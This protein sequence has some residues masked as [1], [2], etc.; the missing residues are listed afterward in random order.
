MTSRGSSLRADAAPF[1]PQNTNYSNQQQ[2]FQSPEPP[3][4]T[5]IQRLQQPDV[6]ADNR[7][8][9]QHH[10]RHLRELFTSPEPH[11][12]TPPRS[13]H[14]QHE[15]GPYQ[16]TTRPPSRAN[17]LSDTQSL[18]SVHSHT[19]S[20]PQINSEQMRATVQTIKESFQ[21]ELSRLD[22]SIKTFD[23][24]ADSLV[25]NLEMCAISYEN[26]TSMRVFID[27][28]RGRAMS[29]FRTGRKPPQGGRFPKLFIHLTEDFLW[30]CR[31]SRTNTA[32]FTLL[33]PSV[34]RK[35]IS[36]KEQDLLDAHV[37]ICFSCFHCSCLR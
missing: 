14:C 11:H 2:F 30:S 8:V 27:F 35:Y 23:G 7:Q 32:D 37:S 31:L 21:T 10:Y 19:R 15:S 13:S 34:S 16:C 5:P 22:A 24:I 28:L 29:L 12:R 33:H 9:V 6:E 36:S 26:A 25:T 4:G 18:S 20:E 17:R 1:T 3:F